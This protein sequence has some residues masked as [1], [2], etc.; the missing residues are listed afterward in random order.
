MSTLARPRRLLTIRET[1]DQLSV[2]ERTVRR[3]IEC[4]EIPALRIGGSVRVDAGELEEW[5]YADSEASGTPDPDALAERRAPGPPAV[6]A[7]A[8]RAGER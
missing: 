7:P 6:E 5:I 3:L 8:A 2:S 4:A 1:A